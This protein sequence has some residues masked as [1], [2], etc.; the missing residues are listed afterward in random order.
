MS[1]IVSAARGLSTSIQESCDHATRSLAG[2][3]NFRRIAAL[4]Y[5]YANC[6]AVALR[7]PRKD[8]I[9]RVNRPEQFPSPAPTWLTYSEA[10]D[11]LG[12]T[13]GQVAARAQRERWP[14]RRDNGEP[15][16]QVPGHL[17]MPTAP[18]GGAADDDLVARVAQAVEQVDREE[19]TRQREKTFAEER[20]IAKEGAARPKRRWWQL[21]R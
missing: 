18:R 4:V 16:V 3:T 21:R 19:A 8:R 7:V 5:L 10:G 14:T 15:E 17:L 1:S 9:K 2:G 13:P 6:L 20:A 12:L 11:L